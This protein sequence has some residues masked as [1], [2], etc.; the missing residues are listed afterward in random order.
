MICPECGKLCSREEVD[1]G[2][3]VQTGPWFCTECGWD[4][5]DALPMTETD[6][7]NFLTEGRF[8]YG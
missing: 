8:D 6:W 4:E 2:S 1:V 3:G 5:L 7:E